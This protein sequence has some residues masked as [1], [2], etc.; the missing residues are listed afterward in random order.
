[1]KTPFRIFLTMVLA[2]APFLA[3][4]QSPM[5]SSPSATAIATPSAPAAAPAPVAIPVPANASASVILGVPPAAAIAPAPSKPAVPDPVLGDSVNT[6]FAALGRPNGLISLPNKASLLIYDRGTVLIS[7]GVVSEVKLIPLT[8]YTAKVDA[9]AADAAE[10]AANVARANAL[11]QLL[12]DD[13]TYKAMSTRDRMVALAKF[14]RENPGSDAPKYLSDLSTV[15]AAELAAQAHVQ[16]LQN[17]VTQAKSQANLAQQ[18]V[19]SAQQELSSY[20]QQQGVLQAKADAARQQAALA[21]SQLSSA[22]NRQPPLVINPNSNVPG[23]AVGGGGIVMTPSNHFGTTAPTPP[24][25][26]TSTSGLPDV[27]VTPQ[28]VVGPDGQMHLVGG[29]DNT[30]GN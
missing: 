23:T 1:M 26:S 18:Q 24:S 27:P 3:L 21:Q 8:T 15:Y 4:A 29:S 7:D 5:E 9:E 17:Q 14:D 6:V 16:E 11:L 2:M 22:A 10:H 13:P 19:S 25:N 28:F 30:T 12:I 20:Q